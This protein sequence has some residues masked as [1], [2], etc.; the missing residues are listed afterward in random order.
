MATLEKLDAIVIGTGQGGKPLAGAL[1]E[2]GWRTAIIE[3]DR[4]GGTCVVRGCT[5][6]KTMIASARVAHLARR[7][8]DY[9]V[10]TGDV[11]VDLEVVRR[12]KRD[13]VDEWSTGSRK[14]IEGHATLELIEGT[15]RFSGPRT[16][17]VDLNAGGD[18]TLTAD[19]IFIN[20][21]ARNRVPKLP[22]L[23][24][25]DHLDATSVMELAEVPEHLLVL[26]GGFIGLE[27]AQMFRRFGARVTVVDRQRLASR[28]DA[29]VSEAIEEIFRGEGIDVVTGADARSVSRVD[30]TIEL[31]VLAGDEQRVLRGSHLLVAA[32]VVANSDTLDPETAGVDVDDRGDILVNDR[33]ETTA[34][35]V[36][37]L[38]DVTGAPPFTHTSYDDYRI[39]REN[40][41]DGGDASRKGRILP[42]TL[43]TDPQLGRVGMSE[44][45]AARSGRQIRVAK[46]PMSRVA[47][48]QETDETRGFMKA[49]VD[50]DTGEILGAAILGVEG[51]EVATVLQM[52]MMGGLPWT[53]LR[54]AMISHPTFSE[55]LNNLFMTL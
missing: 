48:A 6:T 52:A 25:V 18:R 37:A 8:A 1:A 23:D 3:R 39:I 53:T 14:G 43:F 19:H 34:E 12:R 35:G 45:E 33:C 9:G 36:W 54:D 38:G 44:R 10:R 28:E 51:G 24:S 47:R 30:G 11:S 16:V 7:A 17:A 29:D 15:G 2:R 46:L 55:S 22:G 21:G 50:A 40:L 27:F 13:I 20:V 31:D 32:G 42:Y 4:V 41:L 26:G 5:P 49:V